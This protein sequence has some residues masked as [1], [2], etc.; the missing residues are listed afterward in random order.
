MS[1]VGDES[2]FMDSL[3][4]EDDLEMQLQSHRMKND[5]YLGNF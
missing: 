4:S 1:D 2:D 3:S 5:N